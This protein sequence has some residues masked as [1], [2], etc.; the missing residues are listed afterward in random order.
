MRFQTTLFHP[1]KLKAMR[2]ENNQ[3]CYNNPNVFLSQGN[4][5][6]LTKAVIKEKGLGEK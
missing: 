3:S 4:L 5:K 2:F 1:S 6:S